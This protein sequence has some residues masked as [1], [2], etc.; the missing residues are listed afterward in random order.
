MEKTFKDRTMDKLNQWKS[1]VQ[2]LNVQLH[3]GTYEALDEFERQKKELHNWLNDNRQKIEKLESETKENYIELRQKMDELK[4]Q[5]ALGRAEAEEAMKEQE[6]KISLGIHDIKQELSHVYEKS[7][8]KSKEVIGELTER[9]GDYQTRFDLFKVQMN[10]GKSEAKD[11][12]S[13]KKKELA[14][15]LHDLNG[16]LDSATDTAEDKWDDFSKEI[17][18]SWKHFKKAFK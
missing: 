17:S 8:E 14:L 12:W 9:M 7:D 18:E 3:L 5:T 6:H 15:K 13:N 2:Q 16:K 1:Q 4:L 10:L 11:F